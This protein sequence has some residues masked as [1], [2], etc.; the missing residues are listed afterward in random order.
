MA[1]FPD[2]Y[3]FHRTLCTLTLHL[4]GNAWTSD[5]D[6]STGSQSH[7]VLA[8]WKLHAIVMCA[9]L[10]LMPSRTPSVRLQGGPPVTPVVLRA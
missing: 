8:E 10:R 7:V 3:H 1:L 5:T 9:V 4:K 6:D 2:I